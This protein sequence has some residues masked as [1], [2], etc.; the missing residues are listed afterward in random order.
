MFSLACFSSENDLLFVLYSVANVI[1]QIEE[2]SQGV[3]TTVQTIQQ[4]HNIYF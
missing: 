2:I 4:K 3:V 1:L